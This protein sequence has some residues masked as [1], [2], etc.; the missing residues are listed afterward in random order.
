MYNKNKH[1]YLISAPINDK[2]GN[3]YIIRYNKNDD[4]HYVASEKD[5]KKTKWTA[6]YTNGHWE[7]SLKS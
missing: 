3:P 5:G 1:L 6:T 7:E 4:I 2:D